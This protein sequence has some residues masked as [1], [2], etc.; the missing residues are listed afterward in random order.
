MNCDA[1]PNFK[2]YIKIGDAQAN[3]HLKLCTPII[4]EEAKYLFE[5][6][7]ANPKGCH[8]HHRL[9]SNSQRSGISKNHYM[10]DLTLQVIAEWHLALSK[11]IS[12]S[13]HF[14]FNF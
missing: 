8:A 7:E 5:E 2:E 14:L 13:S 9:N 12:I 4:H 10:S 6:G 11:S 3:F 1:S